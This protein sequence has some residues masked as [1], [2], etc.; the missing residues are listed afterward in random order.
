MA[1]KKEMA[2]PASEPTRSGGG[3]QKKK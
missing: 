2:P 3:K 1:P